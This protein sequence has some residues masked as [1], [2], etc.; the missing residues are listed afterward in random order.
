LLD[1]L[2]TVYSSEQIV[3]NKDHKSGPFSALQTH[4]LALLASRDKKLLNR[5]GTKQVEKVFERQL[6]L[7][8]QSYGFYV[9][10]TKSGQKTVDLICISSDPREP[11]TILIEAKTSGK[12]Y[13]LPT[14]DRRALVEYVNDVRKSLTT[15]PPLAFVLITGP[16]AGTTLERRL[17][18]LEAEIQIPAR[19]ATAA[20]LA[21]V[22][23]CMAGPIPMEILR[24]EVLLSDTRILKNLDG[25]ILNTH[26]ARQQ[27]HTNLVRTMLI[28]MPDDISCQCHKQLP[29]S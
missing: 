11:M 14:K 12:P 6:A 26:Q 22:R 3:W 8:F 23:E 21:A 16:Q 17:S 1:L 2:K 29:E 24:K 20:E 9:V 5:Y 4:E 10:G 27:A 13:S 28:G 7:L 19:Y 15:M 18:E 25:G